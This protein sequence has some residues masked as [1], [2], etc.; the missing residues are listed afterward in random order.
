METAETAEV[1]NDLE[2]DREKHPTRPLFAGAWE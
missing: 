2:V 1:F